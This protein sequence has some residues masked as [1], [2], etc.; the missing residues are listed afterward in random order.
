V[1]GRQG[2]GRQGLAGAVMGRTVGVWYLTVLFASLGLLSIIAWDALRGRSHDPALSLSPT[3]TEPGNSSSQRSQTPHPKPSAAEP[4]EPPA[5]LRGTFSAQAMQQ[6]TPPAP[7][8]VVI[9]SPAVAVPPPDVQ[10]PWPSGTV[11]TTF[12]KLGR[13][14]GASPREE[15]PQNCLAVW[16]PQTHMTKEEWKEACGRAPRN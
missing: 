4:S 7:A 15:R 12:T 2:A 13:L 11:T 5:G 1:A 6:T 8:P 16:D 10:P 14:T 9:A 3:A